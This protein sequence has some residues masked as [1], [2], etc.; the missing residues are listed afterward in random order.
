[1]A[2]EWMGLGHDKM[3]HVAHKFCMNIIHLLFSPCS[4]NIKWKPKLDLIA[5]HI[6]C[7]NCCYSSS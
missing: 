7:P 6:D 1:M 3:G 5:H 4:Q 2:S